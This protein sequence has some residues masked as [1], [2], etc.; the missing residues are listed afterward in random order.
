M[1]WTKINFFCNDR[2]KISLERV[3][4]TVEEI[5]LLPRCQRNVGILLNCVLF[6]HELLLI[7]LSESRVSACEETQ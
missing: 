4:G 1:N 6:R 2:D 3:S 5:G 7:L